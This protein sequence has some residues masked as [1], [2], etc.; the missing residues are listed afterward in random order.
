M[1]GIITG[2]V[3]NNVFPPTLG[4]ST[5]QGFVTAIYEIGKP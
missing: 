3:F 5:I 2:S 4:D 1:S